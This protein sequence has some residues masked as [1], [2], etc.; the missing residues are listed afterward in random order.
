MK[1]IAV[2]TAGG[3]CCGLNS[4]IKSIVL[5]AFNKGITVVGILDGFIGFVKGKYKVL[6]LNDVSNIENIGGTILGSSNK[7]NPFHYPSD[8]DKTVYIDRVDEGIQHLRDLNVEAMII[9]GGDGTLDSA[10][11]I[12]EHGMPVIGIPKTIDND[13]SASSPTI[14]FDTAVEN[15]VDAVNKLK[16][17]AYSHR[18]VFVVETMG[19]TSGYLTLYG[20]VASSADIILLPEKEYDI[21]KVCSKIQNIVEHEK[22]YAIVIVSEA[23]KEKNSEQVIGRIVKDS[24]EQIRYGG[25]SQKIAEQITQKTSIESRSMILG[26]LQRGGIPCATDIIL[27]AKLGNFAFNLLYEGESGYIVGIIGNTLQKVKFPKVRI[28]RLLDFDND[29][30]INAAKNMGIYFGD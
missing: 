19:R 14:G 5:D 8:E 17:T 13:M 15:V 12:C 16:T 22:R 30:L 9:I 6:T 18:R 7:E 24:Y 4:A 28:P 3:D 27:A 25:V 21:D 23:C 26:H 11:V 2:M 1:K 10:R 20:G 29:D